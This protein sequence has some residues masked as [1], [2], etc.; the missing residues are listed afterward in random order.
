MRHLFAQLI[1]A[2][3]KRGFGG[4]RRVRRVVFLNERTEAN[5]QHPE[6]HLPCPDSQCAASY[7]PCVTESCQRT[8]SKCRQIPIFSQT[9]ME[10]WR[11]C[12][13]LRGPIG[14]PPVPSAASRTA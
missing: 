10:C 2:G 6:C 12:A 3:R 5:Y 8:I 11:R 9:R 13:T 7:V 4:R 14:R 1:E